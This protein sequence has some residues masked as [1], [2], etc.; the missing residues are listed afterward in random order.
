MKA[1]LQRLCAAHG[2]S[3]DDLGGLRGYRI[4]LRAP[5]SPVAGR[6]V[7][8]IGDAAGVADPLSG[9][10]MFEA[11]TSA[12]LAAEN[13]MAIL[14]G[15]ARDFSAYRRGLRAEIGRHSAVSW[16]AK[17]ILERRPR[18]G[19]GIAA[20]RL[21]GKLFYQDVRGDRAVHLPLTPGMAEIIEGAAQRRLF[22]GGRPSS[23]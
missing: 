5:E 1:H 18:L 22:S 12:R 4:P 8:L 9:D 16:W 15:R 14:G 10:G 13:T 6:R 2:V 17:L 20:S 23:R 19:Y 7:A 11:F 21:G 3:I